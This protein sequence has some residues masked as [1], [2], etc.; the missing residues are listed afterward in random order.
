MATRPKMLALRI[1][2]NIDM[3]A[4]KILSSRDV[5]PISLTEKI[6]TE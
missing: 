4:I 1:A 3:N 6:K 2:Q 5:A